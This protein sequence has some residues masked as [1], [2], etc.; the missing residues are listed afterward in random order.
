MK[1]WNK[2]VAMIP[3]VV[4]ALEIVPKCLVRRL[5]DL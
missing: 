4:S 1:L 3:A 5:K 2:N